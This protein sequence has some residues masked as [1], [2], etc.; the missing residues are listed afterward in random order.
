MEARA[1]A[2]PRPY[3]GASPW[4]RPIARHPQ[5]LDR[6]R[7]LVNAIADNGLPLTS[8][9]DQYT[10]A[11]YETDAETPLRTV[12]LSGWFSSYDRGDA[13]R[14]GHGASPTVDGVPVPGDAEAPAG[15]DG[16]VVF[17]DVR[18]GVEYGFWRFRKDAAGNYSAQNGYRYHTRAGYRGRFA[19]GKAGRGAG[20]P[21]LAGLVR[22]CE[23]ARGR[24]DHALAFAYDSPAPTFVY[25]ASKSDG[26][27]VPGVDL[28]EGTRLQLNPNLR[29]AD[30]DAWGLSREAKTIARALQTYGMY[31]V[32]N[33]G[34]SKLYLEAQETAAWDEGV[35]RT[36]VS[37]IPWHEFRV[38]APPSAT[39]SR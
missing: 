8:D 37:G 25:P 18:S 6:S 34:S 31:V 20:L 39:P 5:V 14:A 7:A 35:T 13:S 4:H 11:L 28:P 1:A 38:I 17:W 24:I 3:D 9:V 10:I 30:F 21:Y 12:A 32:D 26:A 23:L 27:G 19:D 16:Q 15:S 33:S 22:R 36:L 29:E 2:C